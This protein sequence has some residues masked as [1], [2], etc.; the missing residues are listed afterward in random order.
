MKRFKLIPVI[1]LMLIYYSNCSAQ[2]SRNELMS[3]YKMVFMYRCTKPFEIDTG[4][5]DEV[6][7]CCP[8]LLDNKSL[9][10]IDSMS[11]LIGD[12]IRLDVK[13]INE[14]SSGDFYPSRLC[15]LS[16]CLNQYESDNMDKIAKRFAKRMKKVMPNN[17][18]NY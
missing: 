12:E 4:F 16:F 1:A 3:Y 7:T 5:R 17:F 18:H 13:T 15:V 10:E 8:E 9:L 6:C 2:I 14:D 11:T